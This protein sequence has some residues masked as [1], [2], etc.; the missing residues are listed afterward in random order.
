MTTDHLTS[1]RFTT[2]RLREGYEMC[3]VDKFFA[4]TTESIRLRD[5]EI[6]DLRNQLAAGCTCPESATTDGARDTTAEEGTRAAARL[7]ELAARNADQ[8]VDEAQAQADSLVATAKVDAERLTAASQAEA[9][10]LIAAARAEASR[11]LTAARLEAERVNAELEHTR[12]EQTAELDRHR[13]TVLSELADRQA[14]VEAEVA[15]LQQ[16]E[17]DHRDRIRSHL[18]ALLA[19]IEPTTSG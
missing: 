7:L 15:R 1:A 9:D 18:T 11:A 19:Q 5:R 8:L 3:E 13:T 12:T 6:R 10:Q 17:T 14:A 2:T 4:H 16:L